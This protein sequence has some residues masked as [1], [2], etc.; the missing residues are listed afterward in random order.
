MNPNLKNDSSNSFNMGDNIGGSVV[1]D[2]S[3]KTKIAIGSVVGIVALIIIGFFIFKGSS[4]DGKLVG[5]WSCVDHSAQR[6]TFVFKSNHTVTV[7]H[8][9]DE[10]YTLNWKIN[11]SKILMFYKDGE[12]QAVIWNDNLAYSMVDERSWSISGDVLYMYGLRFDKQ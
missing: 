12:S 4:L 7:T 3:R 9:D 11:D 5:T 6:Q 10:P 1:V 2:Q 8:G